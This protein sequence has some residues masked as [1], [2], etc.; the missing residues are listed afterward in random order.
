MNE[1]EKIAA[2]YMETADALVKAAAEE[3]ID[4]D[5]TTEDME[6]E[7]IAELLDAAVEDRLAELASEE[8]EVEAGAFLFK[9]AELLDKAAAS[10]T[11]KKTGRF[12]R[13]PRPNWAKRSLS[14]I[15][16]GAKKAGKWAVSGKGLR[17]MGYGAAGVGAGVGAAALLKR[18]NDS[19]K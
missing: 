15:G 11:P 7:Q 19:K 6:D 1:F 9:T 3:G 5:A 13:M 14:A 18:H 4:L 8:E 2:L 12:E 10:A 17:S 16:S